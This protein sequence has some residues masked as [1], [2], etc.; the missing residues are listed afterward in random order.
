[1]FLQ[2]LSHLYGS[3][4]V[5]VSLYHADNLLVAHEVAI[6][7]EIV[8]EG[9]QVHLKGR[10]VHFLHQ[11]VGNPV[12]AESACTFYKY[13]LVAQ[14]SEGAGYEECLCVRIVGKLY[15]ASS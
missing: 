15:A 3:S 10:L 4:A 13:Y 2:R 1:M 12:K 5:A 11:Q 7:V 8:D 14:G 9:R 6:V